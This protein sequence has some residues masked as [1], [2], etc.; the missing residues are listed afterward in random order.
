MNFDGLIVGDWNGHG[1]VKGCT[2]TSCPQA[3]NAGVDIFMVPDEWQQLYK[4]TIKQVKNGSISKARLDDA[5]RRILTV[6]YKR[7]LMENPFDRL[8]IVDILGNDNKYLE[9]IDDTLGWY[10]K[11]VSTC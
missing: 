8:G 5:V 4:T 2:N 7:G 11:L 1:Q 3:F 6:K 9:V 10:G